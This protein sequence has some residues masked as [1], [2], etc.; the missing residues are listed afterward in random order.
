MQLAEGYRQSKGTDEAIFLALA[1]RLE[2]VL[3]N[4][5]GTYKASPADVLTA[6]M[7]AARRRLKNTD[8]ANEIA[9]RIR[10]L[11][12]GEGR[13]LKRRAAWVDA[14]AAS[15]SYAK[16]TPPPS[17]ERTDLE[18]ALAKLKPGDRAIL[19]GTAGLGLT[20]AELVEEGLAKSEAAAWKQAEEARSR[21]LG[22]LGEKKYVPRKK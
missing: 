4:L 19:I 20:A 3:V 16:Q 10:G 6:L 8:P 22:L 21:L 9:G 1:A 13:K 2:G 14:Y 7:F 11:L 12:Q 17:E 18:A 5:A 15:G